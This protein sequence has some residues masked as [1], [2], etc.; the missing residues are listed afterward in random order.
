MTNTELVL[1]ML[2]EVSATDISLAKQPSSYNESEQIAK[3]GAN[4]AKNARLEL[5]NRT[6]KSAVSKLNAK[7]L[8]QLSGND[9]DGGL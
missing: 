1:N 4:I 6:G 5:E 7:N 3:D 8:K 2:A 9:D